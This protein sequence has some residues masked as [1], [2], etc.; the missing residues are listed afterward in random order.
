MHK[1][2]SHAASTRRGEGVKEET[3][4]G[5]EEEAGT[6][7][8][9]GRGFGERKRGWEEGSQRTGGVSQ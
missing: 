9:E 2:F 6:E 7:A 1:L 4:R 3:R 8:E 5:G